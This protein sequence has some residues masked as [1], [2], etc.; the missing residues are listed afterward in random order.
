MKP[1]LRYVAFSR[2]AQVRC[3]SAT[4]DCLKSKQAAKY[5]TSGRAAGYARQIPRPHPPRGPSQ[6]SARHQNATTKKIRRPSVSVALAESTST[7]SAQLLAPVHIP[8]DPRSVL[9]SDHPSTALLANSSIIIHRQLEMMNVFLGFEQANKYV[10]NDASGNVIGF[11]AEQEHGMGNMIARQTFRTHRSFTT[12]VFDKSEREVLRLHR[13]FSWINSKIRVY[14]A[15]NERTAGMTTSTA[16]A[17]TSASSLTNQGGASISTMPLQDMR[18]IG[19]AQQTWAPL[20]RKYNLFLHRDLN[21][22]SADKDA[23]QITSGDLPL[24]S[25]KAIQVAEPEK[26]NLGFAQFAFVD[27][28]M[29][30]WDFS[31]KSEDQQ[32]IGSVN[33]NFAGLAREFF[34]DT[35]VYALRM[36]SAGLAAETGH[37]ISQTGRDVPSSNKLG[38]T[39]D[40]RAVMLATAVSIDF[41]YFSRSRGCAVDSFLPLWFPYPMGGGAAGGEAGA[42]GAAGGAAGETGGVPQGYAADDQSPQAPA[43]AW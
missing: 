7:N 6:P 3:F 40:Q 29:L 18:V 41:D 11:L 9:P 28:P 38:M 1:L 34:T 19:E 27:E 26:E 43:D 31:L 8:P 35:G 21:H 15:V 39:L 4:T 13:P 10:I 16:L 2:S 42:E 30:S 23:P 17:G 25:E 24:S 20:R 37:I 14:D 33:R 12:H 32:L 36:D 22:A 5:N